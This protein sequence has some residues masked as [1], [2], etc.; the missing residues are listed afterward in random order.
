VAAKA[1][2]NRHDF[3]VALERALKQKRADVAAVQQEK[4]EEPAPE[5]QFEPDV[6]A[7]RLAKTGD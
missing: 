6:P 1:A 7:L 4:Q 2:T 5:P 3:L